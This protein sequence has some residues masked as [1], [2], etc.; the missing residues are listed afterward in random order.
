MVLGKGL[1]SCEIQASQVE[2]PQERTR[3][4]NETAS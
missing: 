3:G 2:W 4:T 1:G